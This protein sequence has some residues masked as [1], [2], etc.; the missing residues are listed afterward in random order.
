VHQL[1]KSIGIKNYV[2]DLLQVQQQ[3]PQHQTL[4][5]KMVEIIY[6]VQQQCSQQQQSLWQKLQ[7][8]SNN[9]TIKMM[10]IYVAEEK[11]MQSVINEIEGQ[12]ITQDADYTKDKNTLDQEQV[13]AYSVSKFDTFRG[14]TEF[15]IYSMQAQ[16]YYWIQWIA[17]AK[18]WSQ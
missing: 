12:I 18:L 16:S 11:F 9:I 10:D 14:G 1:I 15:T 6:Q 5:V 3:E 4:K 17:T 8:K 2:Y 13:L 7:M